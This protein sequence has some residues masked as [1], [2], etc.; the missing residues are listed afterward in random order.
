METRSW[1]SVTPRRWL[2]R[3]GA[4][5]PPGTGGGD[6]RQKESHLEPWKP[7]FWNVT[8][9]RVIRGVPKRHVRVSAGLTLSLV[10]AAMG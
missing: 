8:L 3:G 7:N 10:A 9:F 4:G 5:R 2:Q 1:A 6:A